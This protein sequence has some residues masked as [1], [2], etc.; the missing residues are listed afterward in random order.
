MSVT[1]SAT[2]ASSEVAEAGANV[3]SKGEIM[4]IIRVETVDGTLYL[5]ERGI[6]IWTCDPKQATR[7]PMHVAKEIAARFNV[8]GRP[9][10]CTAQSGDL[11]GPGAPRER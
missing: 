10:L 6:D 8:P 1:D 11:V 7:L 9:A 3:E 2:A 5:R 4:C